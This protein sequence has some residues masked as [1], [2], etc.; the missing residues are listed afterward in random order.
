MLVAS[1]L[2]GNGGRYL[3]DYLPKS[4]SRRFFFFSLSLSRFSSLSLCVPYSSS[5][6]LFFFLPL[7]FLLFFLSSVFFFPFF[8]YLLFL[9]RVSSG[10][11]GWG[12]WLLGALISPKWRDNPSCRFKYIYIYKKK[13]QQVSRNNRLIWLVVSGSR[14]LQFKR[15][16]ISGG[17]REGGREREREMWQWCRLDSASHDLLRSQPFVINSA[18]KRGRFWIP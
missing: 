5:T 10:G 12:Y 6:L 11:Y 2:K 1:F 15:W 4:R 8:E 18:N 13:G 3:R 7:D 17:G 14:A 16:R 9:F